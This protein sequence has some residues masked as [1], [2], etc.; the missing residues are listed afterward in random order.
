LFF[1]IGRGII[2]RVEIRLLY[3]RYSGLYLCEY[4]MCLLVIEL[5]D[6]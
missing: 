1:D 2:I 6:I 5:F 4:F 3:F